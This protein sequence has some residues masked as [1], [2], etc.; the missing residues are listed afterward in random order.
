MADHAQQRRVY[1]GDRVDTLEG[2]SEY[3]DWIVHPE[4]YRD[5]KSR[6]FHVAT[7]HY[8]DTRHSTGT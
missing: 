6:L 7:R 5:G 2:P 3:T 1:V 4:T 8:L